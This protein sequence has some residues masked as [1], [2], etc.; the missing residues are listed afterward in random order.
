MENDF[1]ILD[2]NIAKI[3]TGEYKAFILKPNRTTKLLHGNPL[4]K[5]LDYISYDA[6]KL[7]ESMRFLELDEEMNQLDDEH[8]YLVV[9]IEKQ[10]FNFK[11]FAKSC[12]KQYM[13]VM[14]PK[15]SDNSSELSIYKTNIGTIGHVNIPNKLT[16]APAH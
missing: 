6:C 9:L 12:A 13:Q 14:F 5:G 15:I 7:I 16:N 10:L 11:D 3:I 4:L 1:N 8:S 2:A